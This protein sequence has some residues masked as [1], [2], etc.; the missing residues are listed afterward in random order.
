MLG[1]LM[2]PPD[3]A[4]AIP[5]LVLGAPAVRLPA[6]SDLYVDEAGRKG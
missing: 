1:D 4:P 5:A 3:S 6:G 2:P